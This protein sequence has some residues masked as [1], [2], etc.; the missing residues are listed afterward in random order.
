MRIQLFL[1]IGISLLFSLAWVI[2]KAANRPPLEIG[3]AK[4]PI[5]AVISPTIDFDYG[6]SSIPNFPITSIVPTLS[7]ELNAQFTK[8]QNIPI[9]ILLLALIFAF[10]YASL[11]LNVFLGSILFGTLLT[12]SYG[13]G[14]GTNYRT[15]NIFLIFALL[16]IGSIL[17]RD[18]SKPRVSL[19]L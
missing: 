17:K 18:D 14:L 7:A 8:F 19:G 9:I 12:Q 6:N 2:S 11:K 10:K 4:D 3:L 16:I 15:L 13:G 1:H 5:K